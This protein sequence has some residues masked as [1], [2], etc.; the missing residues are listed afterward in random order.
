MQFGVSQVCSLGHTAFQYD[1]NRFSSAVTSGCHLKLLWPTAVRTEVV[2]EVSDYGQA[3]EMICHV[4]LTHHI[5]GSVRTD[6]TASLPCFIAPAYE[7]RRC[8]SSN[9]TECA[10][11]SVATFRNFRVSPLES[12]ERVGFRIDTPCLYMAHTVR[13]FTNNNLV[14][15]MVGLLFSFMPSCSRF[16]GRNGLVTGL[17]G[18]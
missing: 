4:L 5:R 18:W 15:S 6:A 1:T 12:V 9:H 17:S 8:P 10:G 7:C 14:V 13:R 11:L 3:S 2:G 16:I